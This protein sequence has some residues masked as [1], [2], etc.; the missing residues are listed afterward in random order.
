MP[1]ERLMPTE[2]SDDLIDLTRTIVDKEL[3]PHVD[4]AEATASSRVG[5]SRRSAA[6]DC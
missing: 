4:E 1:A 3:R 6:P 2:E 5:S